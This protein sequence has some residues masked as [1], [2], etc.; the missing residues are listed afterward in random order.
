MRCTTGT[1]IHGHV[2]HMPSGRRSYFT[3]PQR[4]VEFMHD[5]LSAG[6]RDGEASSTERA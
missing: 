3:N 1:I 2:T 4:V 6:S 5:E